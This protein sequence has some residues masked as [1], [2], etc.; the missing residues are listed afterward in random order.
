MVSNLLHAGFTEPFPIITRSQED[1]VKVLDEWVA[2]RQGAQPPDSKRCHPS[3]VRGRFRYGRDITFAT[4]SEIVWADQFRIN[5]LYVGWILRDVDGSCMMVK[6]HHPHGGSQRGYHAW[7]GGDLGFT[8]KIIAGTSKYLA[9]DDIFEDGCAVSNPQVFASLSPNCRPGSQS[10][11]NAASAEQDTTIKQE[12]SHKRLRRNPPRSGR[13]DCNDESQ[14]WK[15]RH[16]RYETPVENM[17]HP[18]STR[19]PPQYISPPPTPKRR[20]GVRTIPCT[21]I[22]NRHL[23]IPRTAVL[24]VLR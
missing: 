14:H 8:T 21:S 2:D 17:G 10:L 9:S 22:I 24:Q 20:K 6:P 3:W 18:K 16:W 19:W 7:L 1:L 15:P 23:Q 4:T 5:E 11:R 12:P 13:A